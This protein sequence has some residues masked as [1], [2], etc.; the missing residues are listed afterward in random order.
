MAFPY[1]AARE[2]YGDNAQVSAILE[3]LGLDGWRVHGV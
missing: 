2:A 3:E 1:L